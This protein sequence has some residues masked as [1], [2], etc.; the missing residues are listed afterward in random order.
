MTDVPVALPVG[1]P[2]EDWVLQR[3]GASD[4]QLTTGLREA[5]S[6][7]APLAL[8]VITAATELSIPSADVTGERM[9]LSGKVDFLLPAKW[10]VTAIT[11][12]YFPSASSPPSRPLRVASGSGLAQV[13]IFNGKADVAIGEDGEVISLSPW[14]ASARYEGIPVF[15]DYHAGLDVLP[16]DLL[17]VFT[18]LCFLIGKETTRAGM[19]KERVQFVETTFTRQLPDWARLAIGGYRRVQVYV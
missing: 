1:L 5:Y 8:S 12:A 10:P 16:N 11:K 13:E 15:V 3:L 19:T 6:T 4:S 14:L 9:D 2:D 17:E 18:Q 7:I